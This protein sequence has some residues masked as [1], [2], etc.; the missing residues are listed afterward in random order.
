MKLV[1]FGVN[2]QTAPVDLLEQVSL[3]PSRME[4][5]LAELGND[6]AIGE[7]AGLSTCNRTEFYMAADDVE[8]ACDAA[9]RHL[10]RA[11]DATR[12][13]SLR[14]A[15]YEHLDG[16]AVEHLFRVSAGI[17]SLVIGEAQ[18]LGQ[19][20]RAFEMARTLGTSGENLD[21]LLERAIRFGRR[22]RTETAIG[23]GNVSVASVACRI[24]AERCGCL[25]Q[26]ELLLMGAGETA[27]LAGRQFASE[28]VGRLRVLNRTPEKAQAMA[29]EL[30]GEAVPID[31][32][33][34]AIASADVVVCAVGAPHVIITRQGLA[35]T[36]D[37][38]PGRPLLLI[39]LSMPRNIDPAAATLD[40]V[41]LYA[42]DSL[43][44]IVE[45]NRSIRQK[46]IH[47]VDKL[48]GRETRNYLEWRASSLQNQVVTRIRRQV[49][50]IHKRALARYCRQL[51]SCARDQVERLSD[52]VLRAALHNVTQSIRN[53]D[54][55]TEEGRRELE[56]VKRLFALEDGQLETGDHDA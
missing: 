38:R 54:L 5:I 48:V 21:L 26:K 25:G 11:A 37:G 39:D 52:S 44:E 7:V 27:Q 30:G 29:G 50:D 32:L 33:Q 22:V 6:H 9:W 20:R 18:I 19:L 46:E 2:Y 41:T 56:V 40:G 15:F 49:S 28:G 12:L 42:I 10:A 17:D 23:R 31:Q 3:S 16:E 53:L 43:Q 45:G 51:D 34:S 47:A 35:A 24:A 14:A 1:C 8:A 36:M 13:D 4:G 55:D